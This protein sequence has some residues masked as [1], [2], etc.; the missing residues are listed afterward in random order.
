MKGV[1]RRRWVPYIAPQHGDLVRRLPP[2]PFIVVGHEVRPRDHVI[3]YEEDQGPLAGAHSSVARR[4]RTRV[5]LRHKPHAWQV[6]NLLIVTV[7]D[8]DRLESLLGLRP[9]GSERDTQRLPPTTG[10]D[11]DREVART[12]LRQLI[13]PP[14]GDGP[15][16]SARRSGPR[17]R[18]SAGGRTRGSARA[19]RATAA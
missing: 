10:G 8:D 11:D 18:R 2:V 4:S 19:A 7:G 3:A 9:E 14:P 1:M 16:T 6:R 17:V 13:T 12:Q 5:R 15:R